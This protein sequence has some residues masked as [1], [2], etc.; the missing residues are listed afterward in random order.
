M[1]IK[2][3][4]TS[5]FYR[6]TNGQNEISINVSHGSNILSVLDLAGIPAEEV[7]FVIIEDKIRD[8]TSILNE[9]ITINVFQPIIGG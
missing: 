6:Y 1:N 9:D 5:W 7:G 3:Q 2:V 4:V 8:L